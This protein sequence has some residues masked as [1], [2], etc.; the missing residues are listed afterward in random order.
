M[1]NDNWLFYATAGGLA[2]LAT[3]SRQAV[4]SY[5]KRVTLE[6][7]T[8]STVVDPAALAGI[9]DHIRETGFAQTIDQAAE[10][11]TGTASVIRDSAG[12]VVG[13]LVLAAPTAR[14]QGRLEEL[15]RLV[16]DEAAAISR[17]LGFR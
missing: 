12:N 2:L 6:R 17:S 15:A 7:L 14:A 1:A 11:V 16:V 10:G 3:C 13:A 5:L 8:G 9:V 4:D